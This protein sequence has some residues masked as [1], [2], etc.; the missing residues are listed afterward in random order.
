MGANG[1]ERWE[2]E[3]K[4]GRG[5]RW[6]VEAAAGKGL[7]LPWLLKVGGYQKHKCYMTFG[8]QCK[9]KYLLNSASIGYGASLP[10]RP[11]SSHPLPS[12]PTPS[13]PIP[14]HP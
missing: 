5:G 11:S 1:W 10:S 12:L 2:G 9:Y 4:G 14:I 7:T 8:Q 6:V 3:G 13:L